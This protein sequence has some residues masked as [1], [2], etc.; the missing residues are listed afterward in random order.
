MRFLILL[1]SLFLTQLAVIELSIEEEMIAKINLLGEDNSFAYQDLRLTNQEFELIDQLRFDR[2]P[3][4]ATD[5]YNRFG[6]LH[7]LEQE[8]PDFLKSLGNDSDDVIHTV[9]KVIARTARQVVKASNKDSA[10]VCVRASTPTTEYDVPRW[11]MDG[12]YYGLNGPHPYPGLVFKFAATLKGPSTLLYNLPHDQ[13]D[14]FNAH[15]NDRLFLSELVN[16]SM[17][18][19]PKRGEGVF[20]IV[21]DDRLAAIHSEPQ[22]HENRLFFSVLIG[23]KAEI[24]ELYLRWYP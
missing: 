17:V 14:L 9:A 16:F 22:V 12:S 4:P 10:W 11:H 5:D 21:A 18:E 1:S 13:R 20:F 2:L 24:E 23:D 8:L 6:D 15:C 3:A 7:L 19:S